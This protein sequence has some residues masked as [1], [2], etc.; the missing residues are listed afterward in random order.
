MKSNN[1]IVFTLKWI[2]IAAVVF[3]ICLVTLN[4]IAVPSIVDGKSMYSTLDNGEMVIC[5]KR[6]Y[7]SKDPE[8]FDIIIFSVDKRLSENGY[9]IKRIIG[10]PGE[11]VQI[12]Y[13]GK[14]YINGNLLEEGYGFQQI[15]NPG[16][17]IMPITVPEGCYFV[18]GDNRNHSQDSRFE[19]PGCIEK[20]TIL[21]KVEIR[22]LP[23]EKIGYI[24]LYKER[25]NR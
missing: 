1:N 3:A 17:A 18:L 14:I 19:M 20:N 11:T 8:R 24:D 13:E 5:D 4:F 12:D 22:F 9:Y 6:A 23:L 7:K 15:E 25:C 2:G 21:G 16:R 10:L